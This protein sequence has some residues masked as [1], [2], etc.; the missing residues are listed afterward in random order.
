RRHG[1]FYATFQGITTPSD[2][3]KIPT[4]FQS[5]SQQPGSVFVDEAYV[6]PAGSALFCDDY[7]G[8][9]NTGT[10]FG[11]QYWYGTGNAFPTLSATAPGS[12]YDI[13]LVVHIASSLSASLGDYV[14][15]ASAVVVTPSDPPAPVP[16]PVVGAGLPGLIAAAGGLLRWWRRRQ[17][18]A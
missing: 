8:L 11:A 5:S 14:D 17:K 1:R 13:T 10:S 4:I 16:G 15:Y 2:R 3:L 12:P 6:C 9:N 7:P 18:T